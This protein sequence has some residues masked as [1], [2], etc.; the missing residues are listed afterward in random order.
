MYRILDEKGKPFVAYSLVAL[1]GSRTRTDLDIATRL[2]SLIA[3]I[4]RSTKDYFS[5][6]KSA[7]W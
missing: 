3:V 1:V 7:K 5:K 6:E 2:M 4:G